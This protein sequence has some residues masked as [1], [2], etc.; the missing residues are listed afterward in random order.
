MATIKA[1]AHL[2]ELTKD[3]DND[4][5]LTP[6]YSDTLELEDI[7]QRLK[8]KEFAV[9]NV[10]GLTFVKQFL[11]ESARAIAEGH[12]VN[13]YTLR[14]SLSLKGSI[15]SQDLGTPIPG[16]KL[17]IK[18]KYTPTERGKEVLKDISVEVFEQSG[19]TGPALK[20]IMNPTVK[21]EG[22]LN[23]NQ[24]VLIQGKRL[25]IRGDKDSL[26]VIFTSVSEPETTVLVPAGDIYPNTASKLQF[27]LPAQVTA[28]TWKVS[29]TT[30]STGSS[31]S[32]LKEPRTGYYEKEVVVE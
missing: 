16:D 31:T 28:G 4:Y 27:T 24:M 14:G 7:V 2:N 17:D 20:S 21:K 32:L 11:E 19:A 26:G 29:V 9:N 6:A 23:M 3:V 22:Y 5:Y 13:L 30:Q 25:A 18:I 10:N 1:I 15:L 12:P 8:D